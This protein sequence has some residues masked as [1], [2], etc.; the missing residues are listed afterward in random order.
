MWFNVMTES[1]M[2]KWHAGMFWTS[3]FGKFIQRSG[4]FIL[5]NHI[6]AHNMYKQTA[7]HRGPGVSDGKMG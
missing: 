2:G 5:M 6:K 3:G 7:L 1:L 4:G